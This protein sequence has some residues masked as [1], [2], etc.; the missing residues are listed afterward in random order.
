MFCEPVY[1]YLSPYSSP[2]KRTVLDTMADTSRIHWVIPERGCT[3]ISLP[4]SPGMAQSEVLSDLGLRE[5][6]QHNSRTMADKRMTEQCSHILTVLPHEEGIGHL[7]TCKL[8]WTL[9]HFTQG[10]GGSRKEKMGLGVLEVWSKQ[11]EARNVQ[12]EKSEESLEQGRCGIQ[13]GGHV[14]FDNRSRLQGCSLAP[15]DINPTHCQSSLPT[16]GQIR[17]NYSSRHLWP[18]GASL[19]F[20][21][22]AAIQGI[23]ELI[24]SRQRREKMEHM[25]HHGAFLIRSSEKW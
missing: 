13:V 15:T 5:G 9:S 18:N 25:W 14:K 24:D 3:T 7:E 17:W 10:L 4:P 12:L 22:W 11:A 23:K 1:L 21:D 20:W 8:A 16:L 19:G 6:Q 2:L